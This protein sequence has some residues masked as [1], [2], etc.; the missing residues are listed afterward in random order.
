[1]GVRHQVSYSPFFFRLSLFLILSGASK[2]SLPCCVL[3]MVLCFLILPGGTKQAQPP[4]RLPSASS[5][6]QKPTIAQN[7]VR[8]DWVG[9]F[10]FISGGVLLLLALN[11]GSTQ[12][13]NSTKV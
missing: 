7:L 9:S 1:M 11:W 8:L 12:G 5:D 6:D 10:F 13:W 4:R 2:K 3:A